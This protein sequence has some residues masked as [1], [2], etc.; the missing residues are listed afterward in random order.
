MED[1]SLEFY[2]TKR[3]EAG[4]LLYDVEFLY[5]APQPDALGALRKLKNEISGLMESK[6][7]AMRN[8]MGNTNYEALLLRIAEAEDV[9]DNA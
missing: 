6:G 2:S 1:D 7:A 4:M 5:A 8:V 9:I 3:A